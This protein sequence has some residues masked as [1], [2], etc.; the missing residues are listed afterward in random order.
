[1][2]TLKDWMLLLFAQDWL[3]VLLA[4]FGLLAFL[5]LVWWQ[6]RRGDGFDLR[7]LL[8]SRTHRDGEDWWNVEPGRVFQTGAFIIT[9]WAMV[10]LV[11][12][13]KLTEVF[14]FLYVVLWGVGTRAVNQII[15]NKFPIQPGTVLTEPAPAE[16]KP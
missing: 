11:T 4:L 6:L 3:N 16:V 1:M 14:L 9:T 12:H 5:L 7:A 8:A 15:G 13:D 10:W 2:E